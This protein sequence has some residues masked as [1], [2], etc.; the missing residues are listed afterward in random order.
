MTPL[1]YTGLAPELV[2]TRDGG[3]RVLTLN[4]PEHRNAVDARMHEALA[5]VWLLLERDREARSVL[6]RA[7]GDIFSAG[8][9]YEWFRQQQRDPELME[10]A[11]I[12]GRR[13]LQRL[14]ACRLPVVMAVQGGAVGLGASMGVLADL[15]IMSDDAFYRDPHVALGLAAADGGLAWAWS[16]SMQVAKQYVLLGDRLPAHEAHRLGMVNE[17]TPRDELHDRSLELAHRLAALPARAAT[18]TKRAFNMLLE[19]GLTG[20]AEYLLAVEHLCA[21]DPAFGASTSTLGSSGF[22]RT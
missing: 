11:M 12:D 21:L 7:E 20:P 4:R 16:T 22:R 9:D 14:V 13:I 15:V 19:R 18:G 3:V 2:V 10:Q 17:V 1:D 6:I 5:E 8:G